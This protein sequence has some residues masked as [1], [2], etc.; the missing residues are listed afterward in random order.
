M[1]RLAARDI[2]FIDAV[3]R[4]R[5]S[6][7]AA[8]DGAAIDIALD[9][10][11]EDSAF[12][13]AAAIAAAVTGTRAAGRAPLHTALLAMHCSLALDGYSLLAPQGVV[14]GM[15]RDLAANHDEGAVARWL[16]DRAVPVPA[17]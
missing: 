6:E 13:R 12:A 2:A 3:A 15:V 7:Q 10:S 9:A 4:R 5:F 8:L 1:S 14:A 16:E 11:R 17:G